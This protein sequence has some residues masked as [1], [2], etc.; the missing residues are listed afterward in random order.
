[1]NVSKT[2]SNSCLV[3]FDTGN[4]IIQVRP[5]C[6]FNNIVLDPLIIVTWPRTWWTS[7]PQKRINI[8]FQTCNVGGQLN[9]WLYGRAHCTSWT[10]RIPA[11]LK[12]NLKKSE[13]FSRYVPGFVATEEN[14]DPIIL[15]SLKA[16]HT[17]ML[18]LWNS[19]S[20]IILVLPADT[21]QL[22]WVLNDR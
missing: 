12:L 20:C 10:T 16:H 9:Y 22:F 4:Q 11:S 2:V 18:L 13:I 5:L 17:P 6:F 3:I 21:Y 15:V 14:M 19:T 7:R 1:M 8:R